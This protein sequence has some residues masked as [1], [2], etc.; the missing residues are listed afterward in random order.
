M[1]F[2]DRRP[3]GFRSSEPSDLLCSDICAIAVGKADLST[4]SSVAPYELRERA[5]PPYSLPRVTEWQHI[6]R[7]RS[8]HLGG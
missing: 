2:G 3:V 6:P 5:E 8:E 1:Q 4:L 7:P